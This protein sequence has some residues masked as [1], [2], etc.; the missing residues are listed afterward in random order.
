VHNTYE[1]T[2]WSTTVWNKDTTIHESGR[3]GYA[4][5]KPLQ[6]TGKKR[7]IQKHHLKLYI[8]CIITSHFEMNVRCDS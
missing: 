4:P 7:K 6:L 1:Q 8:L 5:Q 3:N 2:S